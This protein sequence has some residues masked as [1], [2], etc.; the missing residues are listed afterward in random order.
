[1]FNILFKIS[2]MENENEFICFR[3]SF[4]ANLKSKFFLQDN[5]L[6]F[7][8]FVMLDLVDVGWWFTITW[9][10]PDS[11]RRPPAPEAGIIPS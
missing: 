3:N 10:Q 4:N 1:M 2:V 5:A 9:D 7:R 6:H 11:N 8:V